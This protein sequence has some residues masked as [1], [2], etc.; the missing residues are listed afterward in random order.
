MYLFSEIVNGVAV[1]TQRD[2][3]PTFIT[4]VKRWVN[5]GAIVAY[6]AYDYWQE[7]QSVMTPFV[8]VN[9]TES[10]FMPSD[11][12]K[13]TRLWD[14]TNN[15]KLTIITRQEYVDGNIST[16]AAKTTSIPEYGMVYGV[17][18]VN[19]VNSSSFSVQVKN[20][21]ST[22]I[23]G[24]T[25]RIEGWLDSAKTILGYTNITV[26]SSSPASY[27]TDPNSTVFYG[28]TRI[29][30]SADTTGYIIIAD[31]A[32]TPNILGNIPPVDRE[33]R[34]PVLFLGLIPSGAFNYDGLY[35][36]KIKRMVD[37]NDYPFA[38]ISDFLHLYA[39]GWAYSEEK[40]TAER[41]EQVWKMAKELLDT[42]IRNQVQKLGDDHQLKFVP[43]TSQ[44]HRS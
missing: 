2:Q 41:A 17:S 14:F 37:D 13:P 9:G 15:K 35:K 22:D 18:A 26:S 5:I 33:T 1:L 29:T 3:D 28:I 34:Y 11:F 32:G 25:V 19:F 6:N 38:D 42:Q 8:S 10:Y 16:V 4:K 23:S 21:S 30:K 43:M 44:A 31:Q 7:L 24:A 12:D 20:S 27:V 40:E 36:R 39:L